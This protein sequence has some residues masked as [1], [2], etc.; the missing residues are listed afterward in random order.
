MSLQCQYATS[1]EQYGAPDTVHPE[2]YHK[3]V[4]AT[5]DYV[6]GI[7]HV[8]VEVFYN[9]A[10]KELYYAT[11]PSER[12]VRPLVIPRYKL[13]GIFETRAEQYTALKLLPEFTGAIDV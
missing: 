13:D 9:V 8:R 2:A 5:P 12:T 3:I 6:A 4:Q 7:T 11:E 10:V 1:M